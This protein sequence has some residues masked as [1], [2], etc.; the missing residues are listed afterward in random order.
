MPV[1]LL[2]SGN[3]SLNKDRVDVETGGGKI[4]VKDFGGECLTFSYEL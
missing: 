1:C 2:F 4:F 3:S